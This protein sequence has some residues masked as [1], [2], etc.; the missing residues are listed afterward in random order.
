MLATI[1]MSAAS[2]TTLAIVSSNC[3]M[4]REARNAVTRF[5][6]S[7]GHRLCTDCRTLGK[8]IFRTAQAGATERE[9]LG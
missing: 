9:L 6:A 5:S 4:T 3:E 1:G 2:A 8:E 7:H